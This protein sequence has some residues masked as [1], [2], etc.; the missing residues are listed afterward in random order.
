MTLKT[1]IWLSINASL[2]IA[3]GLGALK[4]QAPAG[5]DGP[6]SLKVGEEAVENYPSLEPLEM[7][8]VYLLQ[9]GN[10]AIADAVSEAAK[11]PAWNCLSPNVYKVEA[12]NRGKTEIVQV[13][14]VVSPKDLDG[15]PFTRCD[16]SGAPGV[17]YLAL[18]S[19]V[20]SSST[21]TVT[22]YLDSGRT[23]FAQ[24]DG[25][26]KLSAATAFTISGTPQSAPSEALTNGKS[27]DVG[28]FTLSF[29]DTNILPEMPFANAYIKSNNN[30]FSTDEKDAKS[31][32]A[33]TL[34]AQR[35][36]LPF[37]YTPIQLEESVQGNQIASNL[38]DTTALTL[39]FIAPWASTKKVLN[40]PV[41]KAPLPP[42]ITIAN[43]YTHRV[44]QLVTAK[45]PLLAV[46]DYSLNPSGSWSYITFPASCKLIGWLNRTA[47]AAN[48]CLGAAF[49]L[50]LWYLPLDPNSRGSK[51]AEGYG[52]AS[53]LV[54]LSVLGPLAPY[55]TSSDPTKVQIQIK[56]SDS[57]NA[58]NNYA[59]SKGWTYGLQV[60]K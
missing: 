8:K 4:A 11:D 25:K 20:S 15:R 57:V 12:A 33:F 31:A 23:K 44:N 9:S 37:W 40:N 30:L 53:I 52:D 16:G 21:V 29:A 1:R 54:P 26:L 60:S 45:S 35:D 47:T 48:S 59:R 46:N 17:I 10:P 34:G 39:N 18:G 41:V 13:V 19:H 24:S 7:I 55:V 49:D 27:R 28:Q 32:F 51:R 6:V 36:L 56:Y 3:L 22:L 38:S 50:G 43:L 2:L 14:N 58:A 5:P 42:S